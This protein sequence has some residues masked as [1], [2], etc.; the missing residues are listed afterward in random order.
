[1]IGAWGEILPNAHPA[2]GA[3][4]F[5][6]VLNV[7][8]YGDAPNDLLSTERTVHAVRE[9]VRDEVEKFVTQL[10]KDALS[11]QERRDRC[12]GAMGITR[13]QRR[14][15]APV[16]P[17]SDLIGAACSPGA[18]H[19]PDPAQR[20]TGLQVL[21]QEVQSCRRCALADSRTRTVR[22]RSWKR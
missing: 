10:E 8:D 6:E 1:M 15:G 2:A 4:D 3:V 9:M 17:G 7:V 5:T 12:L 13:W 16:L 11:L 14:Q 21:S 22:T 18:A 20:P 19:L